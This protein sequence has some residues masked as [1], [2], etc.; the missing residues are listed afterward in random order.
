MPSS[1]QEYR[2]GLRCPKPPVPSRRPPNFQPGGSP[3]LAGS[4][5]SRSWPCCRQ[6]ASLS[7]GATRLVP[8]GHPQG[9]PACILAPAML[10]GAALPLLAG[11]KKSRPWPCP[12][13]EASLSREVTRL[14]SGPCHATRRCS[15]PPRRLQKEPPL[16]LPQARSQPVPRGHPPCPAGA[17]R[18][19]SGPCHATI[20]PSTRRESEKGGSPYESI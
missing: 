2:E 7:R 11:S 6:E 12:R 8:R 20:G 4:K 16:A 15:P 17:T 9:P 13:Q 10:Q 18:L 1:L 5:K 3:F 14:R 19:H